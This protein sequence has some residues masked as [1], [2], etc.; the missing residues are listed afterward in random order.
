MKDN[1]QDELLKHMRGDLELQTTV[2]KWIKNIEANNVEVVTRSD[3]KAS[4]Y[5]NSII[6]VSTHP[7]AS[8]GVLLLWDLLHE[9]GHHI[10]HIRS[11]KNS[12]P[13]ELRAWENARS[14][15]LNETHYNKN[16][17]G[18]NDHMNMCMIRCREED[19][20][21]GRRDQVRMIT[22][23]DNTRIQGILILYKKDLGTFSFKTSNGD[24]HTFEL[25]KIKEVK[26][27]N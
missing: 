21:N 24:E 10:D 27:L 11:K 5:L 15:I 23:L 14:L 1:L 2:L 20:H 13:R 3:I 16:I 6:K 17:D 12:T 8:T 26:V 19:L 25:K 18:F 22:F 4:S 9:Y 7:K